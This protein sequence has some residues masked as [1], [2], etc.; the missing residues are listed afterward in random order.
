[1]LEQAIVHMSGARQGQSASRREAPPGCG[2]DLGSAPG[3]SAFVAGWLGPS[4]RSAPGMDIATHPP[5]SSSSHRSGSD[6]THPGEVEIHFAAA[7][8]GA[9][10]PTESAWSVFAMTRTPAVPMI[11]SPRP[12]A[13]L[14]AGRS[15]R[16]RQGRANIDG[17][18]DRLDLAPMQ[19]DDVSTGVDRIWC[20]HLDPIR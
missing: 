17:Q 8:P 3:D 14:R 10:A 1:M 16:I 13:C 9:R 2:L 19:T 15:S 6:R 7:R 4:T 18:R 11:A 5:G 12:R 20:D